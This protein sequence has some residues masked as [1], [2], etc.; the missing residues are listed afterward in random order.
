VSGL[1]LSEVGTMLSSWSFWLVFAMASFTAYGMYI[2]AYLFE[3][4]LPGRGPNDIPV[5]YQQSRAFMP[6][7][8]GL[9]LLVA[10]SVYC[11]GNVTVGWAESA[12]F[13]VLPIAVGIV[14]FLASRK[15]LYTP[16]DYPPEAWRSPSKRYHDIVMFFA[17]CAVAVYVCLPAYFMTSW[18]ETVLSKL[19]GLLGLA[20]WSVGNVCDFKNDEVPNARQHPSVYEPIWLKWR[21]SLVAKQG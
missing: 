20:V 13:K 19:L 7:D 21:R 11:R 6:G 10:V 8:F 5:W 4:R 14:T 18:S 9:A 1:L 16:R 15:F 12:W 2:V 17:F 3:S